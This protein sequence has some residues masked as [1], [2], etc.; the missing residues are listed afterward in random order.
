M[1]HSAAEAIAGNTAVDVSGYRDFRGVL[2]VGAWTWIPEY[3]FG[4]ITEIA[5]DEA[6]RPLYI[7]RWTFWSLFG[8]LALSAMAIFA[9]M[10]VVAR[11][12]KEVQKA[13]LAARQLG[14][15]HARREDRRRRYGHRLP[16]QPSDAAP[17]DSG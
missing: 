15:V 7:L 2:V 17:A 14:P 3:D 9:F 1:T 8:L 10:V 12:H 6:F 4:V 16:G 11:K 5:A 13:V